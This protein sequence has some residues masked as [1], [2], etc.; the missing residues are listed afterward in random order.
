MVSDPIK[1]PKRI[2]QA[3]VLSPL[4]FN[5]YNNDLPNIFEESCDPEMLRG[6][7]GKFV[8]NVNN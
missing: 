4:L 3:C 8:D 2:K 6:L 7:S 5:L 1:S